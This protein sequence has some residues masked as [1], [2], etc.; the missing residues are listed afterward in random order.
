MQNEQQAGTARSEAFLRW[1][2]RA[3]QLFQTWEVRTS[4][5]EEVKRASAVAG[6]SFGLTSIGS[7]GE[8]NRALARVVLALLR[9]NPGLTLYLQWEIADALRECGFRSRFETVITPPRFSV[10]DIC[11][12]VKVRNRLSQAADGTVEYS[13]REHLPAFYPSMT[14]EAL[15]QVLN[16]AL[17]DRGLHKTIP[18]SIRL[19]QIAHE[20]RKAPLHSD[21][22]GEYQA[23]RVN[24]LILESVFPNE[25]RA[26]EYLS[27]WSVVQGIWRS[28]CDQ[29]VI[30]VAHPDH[31]IRCGVLLESKIHRPPL[32]ADCRSVPYDDA[33]AQAWT[34]NRQAFLTYEAG[35]RSHAL[36][37]LEREC[38]DR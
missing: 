7:P 26:G 37:M 13:V 19:P 22:V 4:T 36:T 11:D 10:A 6:F 15:C 3:S 21:N 35:A 28:L 29:T 12:I 14:A 1:M 20:T 25:L 30:V 33:S 24:R 23:I 34:R 18:E 16:T 31:A 5:P 8:S 38:C 27:T 32:Y 17:L 2:E 9:Y